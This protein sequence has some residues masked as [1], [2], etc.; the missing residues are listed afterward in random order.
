MWLSGWGFV[1]K[2]F[3]RI[4]LT[5]PLLKPL[6]MK[7]FQLSLLLLLLPALSVS[8]QGD[9][10]FP[11]QG[12]EINST[13]TLQDQTVLDSLQR[14]EEHL[15]LHTDRRAADPGDYLFF[16]AYATTGPNRVLY[17][18]SG[19]LKVE[20]LSAAKEVVSTQYYP[21]QGGTADGALQIPEKL[22][23][24]AYTLRAYT[25]WMRNF[26][27]AR[28][29]TLP[30]EVGT[31]N[32]ASGENTTL[33][34]VEFQPEGGSLLAGLENRLAI[35]TRDAR[36][37]G[38]GIRGVITN[39]SGSQRIEM[40]SYGTGYASALFEPH[41]GEA[42][43]LQL[44]NG[45]RYP[46][47]EV[48]PSGY[49]L[50][51]NNL[52]PAR[53]RVQVTAAGLPANRPVTLQGRQGLQTYFEQ[54]VTLDANRQAEFD[55][56]TAGL[57]AGTLDLVLLDAAGQAQASRPVQLDGTAQLR[58]EMVPLT[59]SPGREGETAFRLRVTDPQGK[60]VQ[61]SLSLAVSQAAGFDTQPALS[62]QAGPAAAE[63]RTGS[64]NQARFL[65][66]LKTLGDGN[67][68]GSLEVPDAIRYR[69]QSGLELHAKV[70]DLDGK[71]L[72]D[73]PIQM[74]GSSESD[75][76]IRDARTD[77]S[78]VLHIEN[79]QVEG[80]TQFIFRTPGDD[81]KSRLV[82]LEP[83][84]EERN[85]DVKAPP[86]SRL[87]EKEQRRTKVVETTPYQPYD[88]TGLI[89]L[90]QATVKAASLKKEPRKIAPSVYGIQPQKKN[91][92]Y[93]D[94]ER[95]LPL[96]ELIRRIPGMIV[97]NE[98]TGNPV[99]YHIRNLGQLHP[100][101]PMWVLDGQILGNAA[102]TPYDATISTPLYMVTDLDIERVEFIINPDQTGVFG[103][104]ASAGVI[105]LYTRSGS[106]LRYV[107]PKQASLNF[108]GYQPRLDFDAYLQLRES[109]R[110]L[111]KTTSPTLYWNPAIQTDANGEAV[112]RFNNPGAFSTITVTAETVSPDGRVGKLSQSF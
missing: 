9:F 68:A 53:I 10:H 31:Q 37:C 12:F 86:K 7:A 52:D 77:A 83:L 23:P 2:T 84:E 1:G 39:A 29:A 59:N 19:V 41:S 73:T 74:L 18:P 42:Y 82:K 92:I 15:A 49:A 101:R 88:T 57:P 93:Q 3:F 96:L 75:L 62:D 80:E 76:V 69:V 50:R 17:S 94:P 43:V 100:G 26:G 38:V 58:I 21:L 110:Q 5:I 30:I 65:S 67:S 35:V 111:R 97:A 36:G 25:R 112:V 66:D 61:T 48:S 70:Y 22:E 98:H 81:L 8:A 13:P 34:S 24:G 32:I 27:S 99:I 45:E 71:L 85:S 51:V 104:Y 44:E 72:P 102:N 91:I 28:F 40:Q 6:R 60:P 63:V 89:K 64:Q 108:K 20:L 95:P 90:R 105:L 4:F 14:W 33:A 11:V 54:A 109:D 47:P 46:L 79:L 87:F 55:I 56:P 78:G 107:S 103:I 106:E 16:K